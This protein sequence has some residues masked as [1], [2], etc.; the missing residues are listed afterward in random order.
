[1]QNRSAFVHRREQRCERRIDAAGVRRPAS[2]QVGQ[3]GRVGSAERGRQDI[4]ARHLED[5]SSFMT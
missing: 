1:M 3:I 5:I 4:Y 2:I